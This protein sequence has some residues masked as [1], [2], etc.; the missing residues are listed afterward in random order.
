[1]T[2]GS[3]LMVQ[4]TGILA[5]G[6]YTAIATFILLKIVS[7]LTS[8]IRVTDEQEQQGL[9]ITDHDEKGYSM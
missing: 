1:M 4:I 9:D 3:Q 8:G 5:V 6:I 2:I 7:A